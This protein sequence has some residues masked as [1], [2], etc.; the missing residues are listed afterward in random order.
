MESAAWEV[1][2]LGRGV[3]VADASPTYDSRELADVG[4]LKE[5]QVVVGQ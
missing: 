1:K 2:D 5:S 4:V 3:I